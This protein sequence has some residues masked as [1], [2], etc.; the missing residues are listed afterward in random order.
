M[1][2][3]SDVLI[4]QKDV[5]F[6]TSFYHEPTFT[7]LYANWKSFVPKSQKLNLISTLAHHILI[8]SPCKID[9]EMEKSIHHIF[10]NN[11][12]PENI[13][14][15]KIQWMLRVLSPHLCLNQC[16][17]NCGGAA[18]FWLIE[19]LPVLSHVLLS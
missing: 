13:I 11:G 3:I 14:K 19:G 8:C 10:Q 7:K 4:E 9:C 17:W 2:F 5:Y 12:Y 16:I 18:R 6:I 15:Y 1:G